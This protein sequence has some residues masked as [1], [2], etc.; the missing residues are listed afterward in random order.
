M[1]L[2]IFSFA[3]RR[4]ALFRGDLMLDDFVLYYCIVFVLVFVLVMIKVKIE[5]DVVFLVMLFCLCVI[6]R[7][8]V[9]EFGIIR[10]SV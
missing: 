5:F 10:R 1:Y 8:F 6:M 7:E 2:L 3:R 9:N 4:V